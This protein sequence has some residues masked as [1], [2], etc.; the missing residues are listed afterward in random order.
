MIRRNRNAHVFARRTLI[1]GGIQVVAFVLMGGRLYEMQVA[2][3]RRYRRLAAENAVSLRPILPPRGL[4]LDRHGSPLA[5]NRQQWRALFLMTATQHPARTIALVANLL[6]LK[7]ADRARLR[8][9]V[10]G[11]IHYL[12][13]LIHDE[14]DWRQMATL[15]AHSR[16][17]PGVI[18]DRGWRR[19]YPMGDAAAHVIGYVVRPDTKMIRTNPMLKL[20]GARVGGAGVEL[21][22]N[23]A[24][25]GQPGLIA[26]EI[27]AGGEVV[28]RLRDV[29]P[30]HGHTVRLTLD[31]NL[32]ETAAAAL[33]GRPGSAVLLDASSGGILAMASAPS[34]DPALFENGVPDAVWRRWNAP[35]AGHALTDRS[36]EGLYAPGSS[37][38]PTVALAA[39]RCGAIT[40]GTHFFC[41]GHMKIGDRMFYCWKRSG[42]GRINVVQAL[43]QSCDVFFYHVALK[44]GINRMAAMGRH[45]GLAIRLG[46]D[47]PGLATGFL[48][49]HAWAHQRGIDW[50]EGDTAVQGIGQGYTV[51]TPLSLAVMAARIATGRMP[52]PHLFNGVQHVKPEK[53]HLDRGHLDLV[54]QG[55]NEVVNTRLGTAWG[56]RL[57]GPGPKMAGKTG[58][59]QVFGESK[60]MEAD[61]YN[62][63]NL[64]W[65]K[66][67]NALFVGYAPIER[68][69][70]A[71]AVI[72]EHGTL[73]DPVRVAGT[74]IAKALTMPDQTV[75]S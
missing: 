46:A 52:T 15:E 12:P 57:V 3:H 32:Q 25:L 26:D 33:S 71:V 16:S 67:P 27:N 42:H 13:V 24:L 43:Q 73:L 4:I 21:S 49:T 39:L 36:T 74:L 56:G 5:D 58:T 28:R 18:V 66:R 2:D 37:F 22:H 44:T 59:A 30:H 11:P 72:V 47:L 65:R 51:L 19:V 75:E 9:V 31:Q 35:G 6:G 53:L 69:K 45:L 34:F 1:V 50:T 14:L 40:G 54:R 23:T 63:A 60:L 48:P 20:P 38:K 64:P 10:Q 70:V 55:M 62:D 7:A 17:L 29:Q 8:R 61:N 68:P 41:P